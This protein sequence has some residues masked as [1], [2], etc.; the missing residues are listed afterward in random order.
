MKKRFLVFLLV[1]LSVS[2][3]AK[4]DYDTATLQFIEDIF[5]KQ[6]PCTENSFYENGFVK[7]LYGD[8]VTTWEGLQV[9]AIVQENIIT[10]FEFVTSDTQKFIECWKKALAYAKSKKCKTE[11]CQIIVANSLQPAKCYTFNHVGLVNNYPHEH[12]FFISPSH[13]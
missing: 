10:R 13:L 9:R 3:F 2:G 8:F 1:L 11:D 6:I 4:E 12:I 5:N 7:D